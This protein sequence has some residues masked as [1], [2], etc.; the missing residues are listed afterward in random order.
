MIPLNTFMSNK[1][2]IQ[3]RFRFNYVAFDEIIKSAS[4]LEKQPRAF[5]LCSCMP[6]IPIKSGENRL[7]SFSNQRLRYHTNAVAA[8][9][10]GSGVFFAAAVI[11]RELLLDLQLVEVQLTRRQTKRTQTDRRSESKHVSNKRHHFEEFIGW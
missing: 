4:N 7:T 9:V 3:G 8:V 10:V 1:H 11:V 5:E 6:Q 2:A